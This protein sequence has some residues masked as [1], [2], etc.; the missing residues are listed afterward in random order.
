MHRR[1]SRE[2]FARSPTFTCCRPGAGNR[3]G[4]S[5]RLLLET[6]LLY[7]EPNNPRVRALRRPHAG[8]VIARCH[9]SGCWPPSTWAR[10]SSAANEKFLGLSERVIV[11]SGLSKRTGSPAW[12]SVGSSRRANRRVRTRTNSSDRA[13]QMSD[14]IAQSPSTDDRRGAM[15]ARGPSAHKADCPRRIAAFTARDLAR[16]Q[17]GIALIK[18]SRCRAWTRRADRTGRAR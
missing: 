6:R 2:A 7:F 5:R 17:R 1:A 8:I 18:R 3:T 11:T 15:R 10:R 16:P 9:R 14:R 12:P 13:Q 4:A